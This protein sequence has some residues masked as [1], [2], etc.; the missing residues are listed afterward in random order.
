MQMY[1]GDNPSTA[2]LLQARL[3]DL[4]RCNEQIMQGERAKAQKPELMI[5]ING[6]YRELCEEEQDG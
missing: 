2:E 5:E 4:E 6:L 1:L 3:V